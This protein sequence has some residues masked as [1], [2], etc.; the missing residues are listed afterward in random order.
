MIW[1]F[2]LK[3]PECHERL[4]KAIRLIYQ[5]KT[6]AVFDVI[7]FFMYKCCWNYLK[8]ISVI[9][10]NLTMNYGYEYKL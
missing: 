2:P 1:P 8:E 10:A 7:V 5:E 6:M 9:N 3:F 4:Q